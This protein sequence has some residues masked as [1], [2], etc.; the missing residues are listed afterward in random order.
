MYWIDPDLSYQDHQRNLVCEIGGSSCAYSDFRSHSQDKHVRELAWLHVPSSAEQVLNGM[1]YRTFEMLST[2]AVSGVSP[3]RSQTSN[4]SPKS[5]NSWLQM[6]HK[7]LTSLFHFQYIHSDLQ[8]SVCLVHLPAESFGVCHNE[9]DSAQMAEI[10]KT[11]LIIQWGVGEDHHLKQD[12]SVTVHCAPESLQS[13]Q[14]SMKWEW[15]SG[16]TTYF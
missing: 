9:L 16:H 13:L 7:V 3:S 10:T 2:I 4:S 1:S 15:G 8:R 5:Q 11:L 14:A 6:N 12:K